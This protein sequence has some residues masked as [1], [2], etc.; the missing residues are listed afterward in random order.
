MAVRRAG[1]NAGRWEAARD[2]VS[3]RGPRGLF[4]WQFLLLA[5]AAGVAALLAP[6]PAVCGLLVLGLLIRLHDPDRF[7]P[8]PLL[9][10]FLLGLCHAWIRLPDNPLD[11]PARIPSFMLEREKVRLEGRIV[12][13][14]ARPENTWRAVLDEAVCV[15]AGERREPL[16][17]RLLLTWEFPSVP[18]VPGMRVAAETRVYPQGGL[19]NFGGWDFAE[20]WAVRGVFWR[21]WARAGEV[22]ILSSGAGGPGAWR[23]TLVSRLAALAPPD[24][25]GAMLRALLAGDRS[26]LSRVSVE[27]VRAATLAHTLALSGLHL[28]MAAGLGLGL[29]WLVGRV[30]PGVY[31]S[32]P[33]PRLAVFLAAPLVLLYLWLGGAGYSLLRAACMFAAIGISLWRGRAGAFLDGLFLAMAAILLASPLSLFDLGLQMSALAVAGLIALGPFIDAVA[34]G[35]SELVPAGRLRPFVRWPL[36]LLGASLAANLAL[37]PLTLRAFGQVPAGLA[38]NLLWLP[39]MQFWLM[40]VGLLG[41]LPAALGLDLAARVL[42]LLAAL[43]AEFLLACLERADAAGHLVSL[44]GVRP[45][46]PAMLGYWLLAAWLLMRRKRGPRPLAGLVLAFCLLAGPGLWGLVAAG[47]DRVAVELLD[48]GQ[49]QAVFIETPGGGRTLLDAGGVSSTGFDMGRAVVVP[50]LTLNHAPRLDRL[51]LSHAENDHAGG[52]SAVAESLRPEALFW[53][54]RDAGTPAGE[55]IAARMT[56]LGVPVRAV[57]AGEAI[58]LGGGVVLEV[59]HPGPDFKARKANDNSLVLR[60]VWRGRGLVLL[61]GDIERPGLNGLFAQE[62]PMAAALLVLPHHGSAGSQDPR[63][64]RAAAPDLAAA[65]SGWLNRWGFPACAVRAALESIGLPLLVTGSRG[66]LRFEWTAPDARPTLTTALDKGL[67]LPPCQEGAGKGNTG[68]MI[69]QPDKED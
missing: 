15:R 3:S 22:R 27:R 32:L 24:Q 63:L 8:L 42:F 50:R 10:V 1:Q 13:V 14:E 53:S 67:P 49:G 26:G 57:H 69:P 41:V 17:G 12:E 47:R 25:G 38:W 21:A 34:R 44:T 58:D 68:G 54:G 31:L 52:A 7:R 19:A 2:R 30:R 56:E 51:I 23:A 6:W 33:L 60:L 11:D 36:L 64:Y 18:P 59:L 45:L 28:A 37:L 65:S 35:L 61:P 40:P 66:A 9:L 48:V 39:L 16:P 20:G 62:R 29:A 4:V 43:P 55:G 5:Y 46:W